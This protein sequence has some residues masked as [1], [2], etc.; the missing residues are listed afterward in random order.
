MFDLQ[1]ANLVLMGER[2]VRPLRKRA[3]EQQHGNGEER[4]A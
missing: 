1:R 3:T 2:S 4:S